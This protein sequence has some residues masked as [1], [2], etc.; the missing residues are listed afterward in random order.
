MSKN[1]G[2]HVDDVR[3]AY[4][5][6]KLSCRD[7]VGSGLEPD[8]VHGTDFDFEGDFEVIRCEPWKLGNQVYFRLVMTKQTGGAA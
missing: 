5:R 2:E 8:V 3:V 7:D 1:D 4:T 6:T